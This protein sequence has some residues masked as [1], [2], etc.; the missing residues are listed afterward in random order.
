M[1]DSVK[2]VP[3]VFG[4]Q[5]SYTVPTGR[6]MIRKRLGEPAPA[7]CASSLLTSATHTHRGCADAFQKPAAGYCVVHGVSFTRTR[8]AAEC[9]TARTN[10]GMVTCAG[11]SPDSISIT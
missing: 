10:S 2:A 3:L 5:F 1:R 8:S 6:W 9:T 4:H 11:F 7:S